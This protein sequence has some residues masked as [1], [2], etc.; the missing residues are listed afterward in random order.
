MLVF[1]AANSVLRTYA[2]SSWLPTLIGAL[3]LFSL[4]IPIGLLLGIFT[5]PMWGVVLTGLVGGS[6]CGVV[7]ASLSYAATRGKRDFASTSQLVAGRYDV[8]C[9]PANAERVRDE[10][11]RLGLK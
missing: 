6:V 5:Q 1:V 10:L 3:A 4:G 11:A 7:S 2:A 9:E 8:L